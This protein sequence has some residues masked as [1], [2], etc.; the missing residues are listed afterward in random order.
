[1]SLKMQSGGTGEYQRVPTG[2]TVGICYGV[3]DV[4]LQ[5]T[6]YQGQKKLKPQV[7]VLW[8]TPNELM[9]DGRPFGVSKVYTASM[10]E[11]S[12]LRKDIQSWRGSAMTEEQANNF[13]LTSVLGHAC[14]LNIT[15]A[16]SG[17]KTYT[18]V[19]SVMPVIKGMAIP[20]ISNVLVSYDM[21]A[22]DRAAYERLPD[23]I[24][25]KIDAGKST[26]QQEGYEFKD[27]PLPDFSTDGTDDGSGPPF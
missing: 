1:M 10:G 6:S 9:T 18:N 5:E 17:E 21:D 11:I 14:L 26:S 3:I 13:D 16:K 24:K 22:P 20:P 8:E 4:G 2:A 15:E 7:I 27:S 23:W 12:N 25:R 19:T